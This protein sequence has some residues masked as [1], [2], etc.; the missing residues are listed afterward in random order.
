MSATGSPSPLNVPSTNNSQNEPGPV[1]G[2]DR[3]RAVIYSQNTQDGGAGTGWATQDS[4]HANQKEARD[5][6]HQTHELNRNLLAPTT[7]ESNK[8]DT[9]DPDADFNAIV[10]SIKNTKA[11]NASS[12][13]QADTRARSGGGQPLKLEGTVQAAVAKVT[14]GA[15]EQAAFG[16]KAIRQ[17]LKQLQWNVDLGVAADSDIKTIQSVPATGQIVLNYGREDQTPLTFGVNEDGKLFVRFD[18]DKGGDA[19]TE[20]RN[21]AKFL[22]RNISQSFSTKPGEEGRVL[23]FNKLKNLGS[24]AT[25]KKGIVLSRSGPKAPGGN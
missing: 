11:W 6:I 17:L 5:I 19:R 12:L 21:K 20:Q 2:R 4:L 13:S 7:D 10:D 3:A 24:L 14:K 9:G 23:T 1:Q 22:L 18:Y 8:F 15:A 25:T 16:K